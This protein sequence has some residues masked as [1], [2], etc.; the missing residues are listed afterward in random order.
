MGSVHWLTGTLQLRGAA[1]L[2]EGRFSNAH[3]DPKMRVDSL[4]PRLDPMKSCR[5]LLGACVVFSLFSG[6]SPAF[7]QEAV[8][9]VEPKPI[10]ETPRAEESAT[11]EKPRKR[12]STETQE[13]PAG[14]IQDSMTSE[15]FKA[16]GLD[17]LSTDQL[18]SLNRWLQGYRHTAETK[19]AEKATEVATKKAEKERPRAALEYNEVTRVDDANFPGLTG[20]SI[21][22]LE[23][24]TTWKQANKDDRFRAQITDH[25]PVKVM[26]GGFG[27]KMRIVGTGEFYVDPV[28]E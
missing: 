15:E 17:K 11:E 18:K 23:N 22:K 7:S 6:G 25:P 13:K 2:R 3:L 19:A 8:E 26:R 9:P 28:R 12:V 24:G 10:V 16:A 27:Y 21:I 1:I 5:I 20:H 14:D 4:L